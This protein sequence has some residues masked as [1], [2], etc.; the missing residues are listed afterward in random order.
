MTAPRALLAALVLLAACEDGG[1]P[2]PGPVPGADDLSVPADLA[3]PEDL[4]VVD[5][6]PFAMDILPPP[7]DGARPRGVAWP[8]L[9]A[10]DCDSGLCI[11][12][13]CC[14]ELCD[15]LDPAYKCRACN[16][17]H[18]EG[19]CV[20]ALAGTDPRGRCLQ[21]PASTCGLDGLCDGAG[22]CRRWGAGTACTAQSCSGDTQTYAGACDG[23]G[24][25]LP[26]PSVSCA[27]Y[28]CASASACAVACLAGNTCF[29]GA[30]CNNTSCGARAL[31]QPC[32]GGADC[33]SGKCA[34]GVCCDSD[35]SGTCRACN[36]PGTTGTCSN[37]PAGSDPLGQCT[38]E[39]RE[40][41]GLDGTCD[42]AGAC[43]RWPAGTPCGGFA[44]AGAAVLTGSFCDG[45]GT[46]A[47]QLVPCG[48]YRCNPIFTSCFT[49]CVTNA[50]CAPGKTCSATLCQ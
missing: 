10:N 5:Q 34:Q 27:P 35:C 16:V 46:C 32:A 25:C 7:P 19:R 41:C 8:C 28:T 31:G 1:A 39:P 37:V 45:A 40:G 13:Y 18:F 14:E 38:A 36:L 21:E 6:A 4:T 15:P 20:N 11:D 26:G 12:H 49:R 43:R 29:G 2:G 33:A 17:P 24:T 22:D 30:A 42:G 50:E 48:N 9:S 23:A 44:C 47:G 3:V